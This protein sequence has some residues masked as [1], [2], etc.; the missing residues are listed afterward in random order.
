[1]VRFEGGEGREKRREGDL[2]KKREE[3]KKVEKKR[4]EEEKEEKDPLIHHGK[5]SEVSWGLHTS[6]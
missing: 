3:D 5:H 1:M 4:K 2:K 6:V